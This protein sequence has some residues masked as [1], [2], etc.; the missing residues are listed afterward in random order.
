[1][2]RDILLRH[3]AQAERHVAEG[4]V[5]LARQEDL[6]AML[7]RKGRDTNSARRI[8]ATLRQIQSLHQR[9]RSRILSE[10]KKLPEAR[11]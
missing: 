8:L 7:D 1:M 4:K 11:R 9:D 6:I 2:D 3:L 5:H 10:L